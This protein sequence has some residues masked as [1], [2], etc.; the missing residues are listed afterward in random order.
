VVSYHRGK[1]LRLI[2]VLCDPEQGWTYNGIPV[3]GIEARF[4]RGL[5]NL[6]VTAPLVL[7]HIFVQINVKMLLTVL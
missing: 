1:S 2:G 7:F 5:S 4:L 6:P 3:V